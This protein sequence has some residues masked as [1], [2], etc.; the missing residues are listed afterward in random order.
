MAQRALNV[1]FVCER[2][3]VRSIMAEALLNRFSEGRFR[4]FS[5]GIEPAAD[6]HPLAVEML[7]GSGIGSANLT[8]KSVSE[9]VLPSAPRMDFVIS[10]GKNP[11]AAPSALPGNPMQAQWGI[12]D[13]VAGDGDA[14]AQRFAFR[15]ALRE[16][17]NRIRLFVLVRHHREA[18]GSIEAERQA[19]NGN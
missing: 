9:F 14:A 10:M 1:L 8:P 3:S 7:R 6:V 13:P 18:E 12:S 4:A 11:A 17:E 5:A 15:R 16:L 2:N 19:H